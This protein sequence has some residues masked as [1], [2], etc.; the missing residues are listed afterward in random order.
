MDNSLSRVDYLNGYYDL[1]CKLSTIM[2]FLLAA[3]R[4]MANVQMPETWKD[5]TDCVHQETTTFHAD[6]F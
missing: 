2:S 6:A 4:E 5:L 1:F 3:L